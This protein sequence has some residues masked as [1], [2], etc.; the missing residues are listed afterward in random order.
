MVPKMA[1]DIRQWI[2]DCQDCACAKVLRQA[3]SA[4]QPIQLPRRKFA[5]VHIDLVGP[6]LV[7]SEGY[8]HLFTMVDR[9]T[10]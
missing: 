6:F 2:R 8:T 4:P 7:S 10:R 9:T 3:C 1:S 5:H